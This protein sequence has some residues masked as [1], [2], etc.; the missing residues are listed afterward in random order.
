[1]LA[2]DLASTAVG[3]GASTI[4]INDVGTLITATTVEAALQELAVT[5][6]IT[7][8]G[9][10]QTTA[11]AGL[12]ALQALTATQESTIALLDTI[13]SGDTALQKA[14]VLDVMSHETAGTATTGL[15]AGT[16]W[17]LKISGGTK[18]R[19]FTDIVSYVVAT[20]GAEEARRTLSGIV[21]GTL[22][23][24][25]SF[26]FRVGG[27]FPAVFFGPTVDDTTI[28][29][30]T[31][32]LQVTVATVLAQQWTSTLNTL[33][34]STKFASTVGFNNTAPIAKPTVSGAKGSNAALA[35]LMTA[36]ANYGLVIDSTTA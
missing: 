8:G 3:K 4:G 11:N 7:R 18:R 32:T 6:T 17:D 30:V 26:G 36:L 20:N 34:L 33:N 15:G 23:T 16:A 10:G 13:N 29:R 35:S 2:A 19:A 28:G 14:P 12:N 9:T 5:V 22:Q 1:M 27:N 31:G 24:A 21:A 25:I